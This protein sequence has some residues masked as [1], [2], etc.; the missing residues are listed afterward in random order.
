MCSEP[1][2]ASSFLQPETSPDFVFNEGLP[3]TRRDDKNNN[4]GDSLAEVLRY[5]L[6]Y[7]NQENLAQ[8]QTYIGPFDDE[9]DKVLSMK[10]LKRN[11]N[12]EENSPAPKSMNAAIANVNDQIKDSDKFRTKRSS[13]FEKLSGV[14]K[15]KMKNKLKNKIKSWINRG[16]GRFNEKV[17]S[18]NN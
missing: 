1:S 4:Y 10:R 17:N 15:E 13:W 2:G 5:F 7:L 18:K 14:D 11:V 8:K 9:D 6:K 3:R 16:R 12:P